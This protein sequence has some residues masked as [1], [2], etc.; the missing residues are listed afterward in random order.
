MT[1]KTY[2]YNVKR[3]GFP[4]KR[5][6]QALDLKND[7]ELIREYKALH[8]EEKVWHEVLDN[9]HS[10]GI[11][12]MDIYLAGNHLFMIVE[13]PADFDWDEAMGRLAKMPKQEEWENLTSKYQ[14]TSS[15]VATDKWKLM[16]RIFHIYEK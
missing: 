8:S 13:V 3:Y 12:E 1:E 14:S 10:V 11:L 5:F 15:G 4:T 16:E 7:P 2:G 9:M 6:C